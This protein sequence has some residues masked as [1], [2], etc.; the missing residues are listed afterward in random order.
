MNYALARQVLAHSVTCTK[1]DACVGIVSSRH[2]LSLLTFLAEP[3]SIDEHDIHAGVATCHA[4]AAVVSLLP[5]CYSLTLGQGHRP[6]STLLTTRGNASM[7]CAPCPLMYG[8]LRFLFSTPIRDT[9][10]G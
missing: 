6:H 3:L 4:G 8:G 7:V 5:P 10:E 1:C 2:S 9:T